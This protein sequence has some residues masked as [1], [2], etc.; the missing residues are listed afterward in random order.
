VSEPIRVTRPD[1]VVLG[2]GL[3][4]VMPTNGNMAIDVADVDGVKVAGLLLD[5][6]PTNSPLLMR[7]GAPGSSARHQTNPTS[8]HDLFVR[9][10]GSAVG[11]A[12]TS[13]VV[14]SSDVIGDH[15]WL[16]RADHRDGV[17]WDVNRADTGLIVNGDSVTMYGLFV[18]HYQKYQTIWNGQSGR[19]YFYQNEMPYEAPDQAAWMNGSTRGY[20]A[21]KVADNVT[22]HEVW[23]LGSYIFANANLGVVADQAFEVPQT[24]G[25]RFHGMVTISL[26]GKGTIEHIINNSGGRVTDGS[27]EA[28]LANYP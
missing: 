11:R 17:G 16:W 12:T 20:A 7:I 15:L 13:L 19:T 9:I 4:T 5:A 25:V 21:Y 28:Y 2:L 6:A 23:G 10:G 8:V 22:T 26:G 18:E 3:A 1:T 27:T 14:N 24:P